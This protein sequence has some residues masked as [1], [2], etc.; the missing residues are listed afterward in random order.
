MF[1]DVKKI[2]SVSSAITEYLGLPIDDSRRVDVFRLCVRYA[3]KQLSAA[4]FQKELRTVCGFPATPR[5]R[6]DLNQSVYFLRDLRAFIIR[7]SVRA[8]ETFS[9]YIK[10]YKIHADDAELLKATFDE[11]RKLDV[12]KAVVRRV[13][14]L[15]SLD[16]KLDEIII[17]IRKF[18]EKHV[19]KKLYFILKS[20]NYEAHDL[21]S[22]L[23]CKAISTF[24]ATSI[25]CKSKLHTLNSIKLTCR[26]HATNMI[27]YFTAKKRSRLNR[28]GDNTFSLTVVSE[29]QLIRPSTDEEGAVTPFEDM[30]VTDNT[31]NLML[32]I[33]VSQIQEKFAKKIENGENVAINSKKLRFVKLLMGYH[34]ADFTKFLKGMGINC[35]NDEYQDRV[36]PKRYIEVISKYLRIP[37]VLSKSFVVSLRSCLA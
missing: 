21:V 26:N 25:E 31:S 7:M 35:G 9:K 3:V 36:Q 4:Q 6:C 37:K 14:N 24:Y 30:C 27:N 17:D 1:S 32:S 20:C 29:N 23:L 34:D 12:E 16:S 11:I 8:D 10:K 19:K 5:F 33:S 22:E 28:T 18:C 13:C 2:E 15:R